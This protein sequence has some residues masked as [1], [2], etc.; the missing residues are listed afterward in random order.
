MRLP[1]LF[2]ALLVASFAAAQTEEIPEPITYTS[3]ARTMLDGFR[4]GD[5]TWVF[6]D[7][8]NVRTQPAKDAPVAAQLVGGEQVIVLD[9][10][11][12]MLMN[13]LG[14]RWLKVGFRKNGAAQEGY[15]WGG[16]LAL[17]SVQLGDMR[18][19]YGATSAKIEE[20]LEGLPAFQIEVRAFPANGQLRAFATYKL[21][22]PGS[23]I[24]QIG[25]ITS[26]GLAQF[27]VGG[28]KIWFSGEA[29][30]Y[31]NYDLYVFWDGAKLVPLP[32]LQSVADG[33]MLYH[34]EEYIFPYLQPGYARQPDAIFLKESHS[35]VIHE[36]EIQSDEWAK[37]RRMLWDGK[38][39]TKPSMK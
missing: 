20:G 38:K 25:R 21:D 1:F 16:L 30:G 17:G 15:V 31:P 2:A 22:M 35:E 24:S 26:L 4:P 32:S 6:G 9:T 11:Q 10:A 29:C 5:T 23:Y 19:V 27:P 3:E 33:G 13:G 37:V 34:G 18:V 7:K 36:D 28:V 12:F 8:I 39:F 14:Q